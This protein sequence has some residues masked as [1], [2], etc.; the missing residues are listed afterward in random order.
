VTAVREFAANGFYNNNKKMLLAFI[1]KN[2]VTEL[3]I[4][5]SHLTGQR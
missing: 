3:F 5:T 4:S 1:K 2:G